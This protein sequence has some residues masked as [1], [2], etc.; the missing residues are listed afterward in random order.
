MNRKKI[1][2][3]YAIQVHGFNE[4]LCHYNKNGIVEPDNYIDYN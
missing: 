4:T 1:Q 2:I 3:V